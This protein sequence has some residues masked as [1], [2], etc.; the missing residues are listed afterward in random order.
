MTTTFVPM[1]AADA[2]DDDDVD[3]NDNDEGDD[4]EEHDVNGVQNN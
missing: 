2:H 4:D 1:I 3:K